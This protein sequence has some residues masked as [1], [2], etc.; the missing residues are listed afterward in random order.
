[1]P[2]STSTPALVKLV[3][4]EPESAAVRR[5]LRE[6]PDRASCALAKVEVVRAV[7][8]HGAAA[9]ATARRLLRRIDLI[10]LDDELLDAA[11]DQATVISAFLSMFPAVRR[12]RN[13]K[14]VLVLIT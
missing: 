7:R 2:W 8:P 3:V 1:M 10:Q 14:V 4:A 9:V 5:T 13:D 11:A 12:A 6:E